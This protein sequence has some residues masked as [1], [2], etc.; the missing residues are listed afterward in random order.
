MSE[1]MLRTFGI[2]KQYGT[3]LA[4]NNVSM[5][6]KKGDI[7]GFIG[8]NGAGKSTLIKI[9]M[10]LASA[11]KGE[12]E[13]F[14]SKEKSGLDARR[15]RIGAIIENPS[16]HPNLTAYD[17]LEYIRRIYGIVE[18][19]IIDVLEQVGLSHTGNKKAGKFSLGM[20]QRLGLGMSLLVHPDFLIL[21]EPVNG[22]DP[23]GIVEV[24]NLLLRLNKENN[25]TIL[26]S[27]H[28]L[29]ELSRIA[30]C[31]G[32]I[33]EGT[34]IEEFSSKELQQKGQG[35]IEIEVDKKDVAT[36]ILESK[37]NITNY[38]VFPE[39]TIRIYDQQKTVSEINL[40]LLQNNVL[41]NRMDTKGQ[42]LEEYFIGIE[43]DGWKRG[44][45]HA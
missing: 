14:G 34:L 40:C 20:K 36:F 37:L 16:I 2:T 30:T 31:Y 6:V 4:L 38:E 13:L 43:N 21:D 41:V 27:S 44:N 8:R 32:I 33:K 24:R 28:M 15:R 12:I 29:D 5:T 9:V 10:G 1:Y 26:I 22:M 11:T 42:S 17:N 23:Q 3:Q 35:Y 45:T 39:N 19:N 25:I 7:Y 18:N